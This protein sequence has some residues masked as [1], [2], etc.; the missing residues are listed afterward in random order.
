[1]LPPSSR[2]LI[3]FSS[4]RQ[5]FAT[6]WCAI[7]HRVCASSS[8]PPISHPQPCHQWMTPQHTSFVVTY[9][10]GKFAILSRSRSDSAE[11]P[12]FLLR[13]R[14]IAKARSQTGRRC[15]PL[16][17]HHTMYISTAATADASRHTNKMQIQYYTVC[18]IRLYYTAVL[19]FLRLPLL[20]V[21]LVQ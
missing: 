20:I 18:I 16:L 1:M 7:P 19:Y 6:T 12:Y 8:S 21:P 13:S 11:L 9:D 4:A 5:A 3:Q 2:T 10:A 17:S 14:Q 15:H